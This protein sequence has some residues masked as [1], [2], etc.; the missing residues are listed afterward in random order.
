MNQS[1]VTIIAIGSPFGSSASDR[2]D[3]HDHRP[4]NRQSQWHIT[5]DEQQHS[6]NDLR[7]ADHV[8]RSAYE[9]RS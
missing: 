9:E 7:R 1:T 4:E 8:T 6:T 3:A 2:Q 5:V